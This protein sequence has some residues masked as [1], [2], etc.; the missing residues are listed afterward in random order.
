MADSLRPVRTNTI[1][2]H[3]CL[4]GVPAVA[5][6]SAGRGEPN[7]CFLLLCPATS[8]DDLPEPFE[9]RVRFDVQA[10]TYTDVISFVITVASAW[11]H[12]ESR[13]GPLVSV[14]RTVGSAG[15]RRKRQTIR[16]R[17]RLLKSSNGRR[18][19][20]GHLSKSK[21]FWTGWVARKSRF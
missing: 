3:A 10:W 6:A 7:P 11:K 17:S 16:R 12:P 4:A 8:T 5:P 9:R 1:S 15:Y 14:I 13:I 21:M 2:G 18:R 20:S 19:S